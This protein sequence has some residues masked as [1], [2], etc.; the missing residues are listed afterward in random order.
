MLAGSNLR[1]MTAVV[2]LLLIVTNIIWGVKYFSLRKN[3]RV[4]QMVLEGRGISERNLE[5]TKLFIDDVIRAQG[6]IDFETRLKLESAV[7]NLE[8]AEVL[9]QWSKFVESKTGDE[10]QRE[11]K[12]LLGMLINKIKAQ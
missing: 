10:A 8:D 6:E 1:A 4:A 9:A 12:N 7:R 5:F 3:Y 11:I 2:I